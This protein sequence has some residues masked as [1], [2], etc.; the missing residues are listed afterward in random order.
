M[1]YRFFVL[2]LIFFPVLPSPGVVQAQDDEILALL[3]SKDYEA[4]RE[5]VQAWIKQEP[6]S[7]RT[8]YFEALLEVDAEKAVNL[9]NDI[10]LLHKNSPYAPLAMFKVAQFYY[11]KGFYFSAEQYLRDLLRRY[12][13]AP[14]AREAEYYL[15]ICMAANGKPDSA[16][17]TLRKLLVR[18]PGSYLLP[19][20]ADDYVAMR[21]D[22]P[23]L[24]GKVGTAPDTGVP[25][26]PHAETV[27]DKADQ[28]MPRPGESLVKQKYTIQ[29]GAFTL[30]QN[31]HKQKD[32]F[33]SLGYT[34][35]VVRARVGSRYFYKVLVGKFSSYDE[36]DRAARRLASRHGVNYRIVEQGEL[37]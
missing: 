8:L 31:A 26:P 20:I 1:K 33:T 9:Y 28:K 29:V 11:M 19:I 36:A 21:H 27:Q 23:P 34:V 6:R 16:R 22:E 2:W 35:D 3:G 30:Y 25:D 4:V 5:K 18:R 14:V 37:Q 32:F 12:P 17:I 13:E 15:A 7:P 24:A 10:V